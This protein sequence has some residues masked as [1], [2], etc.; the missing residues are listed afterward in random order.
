MKSVVFALVGIIGVQYLF[1]KDIELS[2]A[3]TASILQ[4]SAPIFIYAYTVWT[5]EK[6]KTIRE[7]ICSSA[8]LRASFLEPLLAA[9]LAVVIFKQVFGFY[10]IVGIIVVMVAVL[11][12]A[13]NEDD[14]NFERLAT[15]AVKR[16]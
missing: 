1:Y 4:F 2:N 13:K 7:I 8:H 5:G 9:V 16:L 11:I 10:E 14:S 15:R 6:R 12:L 3:S